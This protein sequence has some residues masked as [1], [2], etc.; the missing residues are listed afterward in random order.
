VVNLYSN[1]YDLFILACK[2]IHELLAN[3][4]EEYRRYCDKRERFPNPNVRIKRIDY[5]RVD[6]DIVFLDQPQSDTK[7][8]KPTVW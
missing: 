6:N 2:L 1:K 5:P 8:T 4:I 7:G 3:V